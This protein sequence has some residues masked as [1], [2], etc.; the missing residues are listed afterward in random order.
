[1]VERLL[2]LT[3]VAPY[4]PAGDKA[5]EGRGEITAARRFHCGHALRNQLDL[6]RRY[7]PELLYK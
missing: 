4:D 2:G 6:L 5:R 3:W 1:M 7:I